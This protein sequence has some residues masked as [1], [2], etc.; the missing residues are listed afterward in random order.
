MTEVLYQEIAREIKAIQT[1]EQALLFDE[2]HIERVNAL[3][4]EETNIELAF[5]EKKVCE[6]E[7]KVEKYFSEKQNK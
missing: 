1:S 4:P 5:L 3:T 2:K 7:A 6:I